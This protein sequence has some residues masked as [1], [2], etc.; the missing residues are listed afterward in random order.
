MPARQS[1]SPDSKVDAALHFA[2]QLVENRGWVT[3]EDLDRVRRVGHGDAVIAEIDA[4]VAWKTFSNYFNHVAG[5]DV[6]F[7]AVPEVAAT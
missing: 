4:V 7:P 3:D 1:T 6:D 2:R 5:T